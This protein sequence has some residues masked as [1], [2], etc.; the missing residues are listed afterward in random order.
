MSAKASRAFLR[1]Y[2]ENIFNYS[3]LFSMLWCYF[4][5]GSPEMSNLF[6]Q[7]NQFFIS[8]PYSRYRLRHGLR[9]SLPDNAKHPKTGKMQA[10]GCLDRILRPLGYEMKLL[11]HMEPAGCLPTAKSAGSGSMQEGLL[12]LKLCTAGVRLPLSGSR[13]KAAILPLY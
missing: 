11:I 6:M 3:Y 10:F 1:P 2:G 12:I 7:K 5:C 4:I 9:T 13:R 8:L